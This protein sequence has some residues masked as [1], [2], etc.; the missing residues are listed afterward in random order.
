MTD[1]EM[2]TVSVMV[3]PKGE[4]IFSER[5]TIISIADEGAGEFLKITQQSDHS[6]AGEQEISIEPEE[7]PHIKKAVEMM[8]GQIESGKSDD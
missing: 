8:I 4:A 6:N 7:W 3:V 2:R 5:A 1:Y